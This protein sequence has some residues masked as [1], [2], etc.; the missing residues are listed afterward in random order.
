[1]AETVLLT[2]SAPKSAA[3]MVTL[4]KSLGYSKIEVATNG[5]E[6]RRHVGIEDFDL[7][8]VNA[9]LTDEFGKELA[10]ELTNTTSASVVL[11]VKNELTEDLTEKMELHG[12]L[13]VGKPLNRQVFLQTLKFASAARRRLIGLHQKNQ[14]LQH[15]IEEIR[16]V[17][18]AKWTLTERGA[19]TEP[20]AHRYIEKCAMN[21]RKTRKEVA[22][23]ILQQYNQ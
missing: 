23:N 14:K 20:E 6:A 17:E 9:P 5:A 19:M 1:M 8:L 18:R 15:K 10:V 16:V 7:V 3:A 13:V 4:L 2:A 21:Q 11:I 22:D 12:V